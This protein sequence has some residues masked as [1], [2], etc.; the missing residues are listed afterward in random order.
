MIKET[1]GERGGV[2]VGEE[3]GGG[4]KSLLLATDYFPQTL[5][6]RDSYGLSLIKL[7]RH[8]LSKAIP[9]EQQEAKRTRD[10][11]NVATLV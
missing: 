5:K 8:L 10:Q 4:G 7:D 11:S 2:K 9:E 3:D 6:T 1:R